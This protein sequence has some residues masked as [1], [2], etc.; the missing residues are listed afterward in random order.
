MCKCPVNSLSQSI[1]INIGG[2]IICNSLH[3]CHGISHSDAEAG[4][5]DKLDVVHAVADGHRI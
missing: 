2:Y 3:R 4:G 1:L 5:P